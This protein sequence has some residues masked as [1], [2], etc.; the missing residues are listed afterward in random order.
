MDFEKTLH[1]EC[2]WFCFQGVLQASL[3]KMKEYW[4]THYIRSS[5]HD[6]IPGI[7]DILYYLPERSRGMNCLVP[8]SDEKM[9]EITVT[10]TMKKQKRIILTKNIFNTL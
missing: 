3:N 4:N 5:R 10:S 2:I 1:K 6:T 9:N 7:P 8:V